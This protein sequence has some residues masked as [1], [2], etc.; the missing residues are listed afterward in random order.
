[1]TPSSIAYWTFE[2]DIP[3]A[4]LMIFFAAFF[5]LLLVVDKI[6]GKKLK[7]G[8]SLAISALVVWVV[9]IL[10]L[11]IIYRRVNGYRVYNL[12]LIRTYIR[13]I[14]GSDRTCKDVFYNIFML[15]PMGFLIPIIWEKAKLYHAL[16]ACG[17]FS[18][19]IEISQYL[20][21]R[22]SFELG[23][24]LHNTLG[25]L[26]GFIICAAVKRIVGRTQGSQD[27]IPT[28]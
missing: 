16:L 2:E 20:S 19:A 18:L 1:M 15:M 12:N 13:A 8:R 26:V 28:F 27:D 23:D 14:N 11:T 5:V 6:R 10:M 22:G 17:G 24:L 25:A 9:L 3:F 21:C 7:P 4:A